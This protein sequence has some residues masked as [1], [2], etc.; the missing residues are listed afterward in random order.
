MKPSR[1]LL[2]GSLF[3]ATWMTSGLALSQT[4]GE[5]SDTIHPDLNESKGGSKSE[6]NQSGVPLPKND[7]SS[8]TVEEGKSGSSDVVTPRSSK[9]PTKGSSAN[10]TKGKDTDRP[11]QTEPPS[12]R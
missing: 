5:R 8:G 9:T 4:S 3:L 11:N 6:R 7:P 2:S 10:T 1:L 12:P